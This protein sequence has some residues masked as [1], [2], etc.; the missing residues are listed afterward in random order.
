[1]LDYI[2]RDFQ[3]HQVRALC[4]TLGMLIAVGVSLTLAA[5]TPTVP[6]V[7]CYL[8]WVVSAILLG[9]CSWHRGSFGLAVT[10]SA[11]LIIDTVGLLRTLGVF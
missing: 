1:M 2:R 8:G 7:P 11:F 4:E 5:T 10:Y 3:S 6:L 9:G